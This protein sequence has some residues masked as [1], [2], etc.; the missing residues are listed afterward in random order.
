M[1]DEFMHIGDVAARAGVSP[2][3]IRHYE[4]LGLIPGV[5]REHSGFRSFGPHALR[6]VLLVR[7]ALVFGFT[8]MEL[9]GYF[10]AR[11]RG[12]APCRQVR[13]AA[14]R[15]LQEV[16]AQLTELRELRREMRRVLRA[17]D[18]ALAGASDGVAVRL[19]DTLPV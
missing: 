6:R 5:T 18:V 14:E 8:L 11:D 15:K 3:T 19:L 7:R 1:V 17:W 13:D 10:T 16:A 2:D 9:R 12:D 4:R